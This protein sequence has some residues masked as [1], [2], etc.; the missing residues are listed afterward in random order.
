MGNKCCSILLASNSIKTK[1]IIVLSFSIKYQSELAFLFSRGCFLQ[2]T[3]IMMLFLIFDCGSIFSKSSFNHQL[4]EVLEL[5]LHLRQLLLQVV[6]LLFQFLELL[7]NNILQGLHLLPVPKGCSPVLSLLPLL[8]VCWIG[9]HRC[10]GRLGSG[11]LLPR[12]VLTWRTGQ[13]SWR[14]TPL[15]VSIREVSWRCC[16]C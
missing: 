8:L 4:L 1:I 11:V 15:G 14:W 9:S 5:S 7:L 3:D 13:G 6:V 10:L 12:L 2:L 16:P